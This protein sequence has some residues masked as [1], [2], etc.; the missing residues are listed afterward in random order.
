MIRVERVGE[1]LPVWAAGLA[2]LGLA[3]L[4]ARRVGPTAPLVVLLVGAGALAAPL[5]RAEARAPA[6]RWLG[7]VAV[8]TAAVAIVALGARTYSVPWSAMGAAAAVVAAVAEEAFFRR[9]LYGWLLRWGVVAAVSA[10]ALVF[11]AVHVPMYG[12]GTLALNAAAGLLF[13]WQRWAAGTWTAPAATHAAA[14]L[15]AFL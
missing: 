8:G 13:G 3:A 7:V 15:L 11:A 2:V 10:T 5:P 6:S 1:R 4:A 12:P 14:N 9:F